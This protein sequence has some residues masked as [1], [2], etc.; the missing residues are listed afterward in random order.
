[1]DIYRE[2]LEEAIRENQIPI[3][4]GLLEERPCLVTHREDDG[5]G[6]TVLMRAV[7]DLQAS[8][9]CLHVLL[10][11]GADVNAANFQGQT[12]L[13]YTIIDE[14]WGDCPWAATEEEVV[15]FLVTAGAR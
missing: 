14:Y 4:K 8:L 11:A 7:M 13:H 3:V 1:M 2:F 12:A 15:R 5:Y 10:D 9:E 6:S